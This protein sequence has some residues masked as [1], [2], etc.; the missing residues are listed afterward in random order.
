MTKAATCEACGMKVDGRK[1]IKV[2]TTNG[3]LTLCKQCLDDIN[4][5]SPLLVERE[6]EAAA[7]RKALHCALHAI[8]HVL[9]V[10]ARIEACGQ[11]GDLLKN[12]NAVGTKALASNAGQALLDE[13]KELTDR[14]RAAEDEIEG[15]KGALRQSNKSKKKVPLSKVKEIVK[16]HAECGGEIAW[17]C[18]SILDNL[19]SLLGEEVAKTCP[20][21][22]E[23]DET[24]TNA[25]NL[26]K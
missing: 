6:A 5:K 3:A 17:A 9:C 15:L 13:H 1:W 2:R 14:L 4:R 12:A 22:A 10:P 18:E 20:T 8:R 23:R 7:M 11:T 19:S 16:Q 21:N 26:A 25:P 24:L